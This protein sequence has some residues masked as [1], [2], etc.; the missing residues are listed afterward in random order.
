MGRLVYVIGP[1]GA[2][3]DALI[4]FARQQL[5]QPSGSL[6]EPIVPVVF[7]HRYITRASREG[8]N[9]IVLS[10]DEFALRSARGLFALEWASHALR[11]G[12][13]VELDS[14]LARGLRVVVNGSRAYLPQVLAR[15]PQAEVVHVEAAPAVLAARLGTRQRE[16][17]GQVA[18][19]LA[20]RVPFTLPDDTPFTAI[21]NSGELAIAG[22]AFVAA[23]RGASS[24]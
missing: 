13:G 18:E 3:K 11:Y 23:V 12:I 8:E 9:H 2:G 19:R 6:S 15:Y 10:A 22:A 14:W 17:A 16:T 4:Q 7:A 1:S 24:H 20:R 21:D 5:G